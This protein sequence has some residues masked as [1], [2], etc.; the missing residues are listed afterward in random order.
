M[1]VGNNLSKGFGEPRVL[2][3]AAA[4]RLLKNIPK[5]ESG[6]TKCH[7]MGIPLNNMSTSYILPF[8]DNHCCQDM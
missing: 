1:K 6:K 2:S 4:C 8:G 3:M 7:N 5:V